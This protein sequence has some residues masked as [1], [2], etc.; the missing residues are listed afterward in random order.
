MCCQTVTPSFH[1]PI[2]D[3][4]LISQSQTGFLFELA[5]HTLDSFIGN[6]SGYCLSNLC[7]N[8]NSTEC[9]MPDEYYQIFTDL[10]LSSF[11]KVMRM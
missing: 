10:F 3:Q 1:W 6:K 4:I 5:N 2:T 8:S 11:A 9:G 7:G